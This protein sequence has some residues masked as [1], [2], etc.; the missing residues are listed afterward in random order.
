MTARVP[1]VQNPQPAVESSGVMR[2]GT[3][4]WTDL[5]VALCYEDARTDG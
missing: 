4:G 5:L 1:S 2:R 3:R